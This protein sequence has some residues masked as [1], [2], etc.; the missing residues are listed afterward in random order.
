MNHPVL[1]RSRRLDQSFV[2]LGVGFH[3]YFTG[4]RDEQRGLVVAC[5]EL[6]VRFAQPGEIVRIEAGF[7]TSCAFP[8]PG[9]QYV[10]VRP[11]VNHQVG[12]HDSGPEFFE[13][14]VVQGQLC[15]TQGETGEEPVL[16]EKIIADRAL[17]EQFLLEQLLLLFETR[18]EKENLCLKG[19]L[20]PVLVEQRQERVFF[21]HFVDGPGAQTRSEHAGEGGLPDTDRAFHDNV[22]W[23]PGRAARTLSF[24]WMVVFGFVTAHFLARGRIEP[25]GARGCP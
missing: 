6:I 5:E 8:N 17:S 1:Q 22:A 13:D 19:I 11:K 14:S 9:Q 10:Q 12:F 21:H 3:V 18:Q 4:V 25:S 23:A 15:G 24:L 2:L 7:E 16:G 20:L